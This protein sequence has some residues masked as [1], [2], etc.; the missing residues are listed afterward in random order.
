MLVR[1]F[2]H[3]VPVCLGALGATEAVIFFGA[4]YFGIATRPFGIELTPE[5]S[6]PV[7]PIFPTAV[8]VSVH[9]ALWLPVLVSGIPRIGVLR[10]DITVPL[11]EFAA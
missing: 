9:W 7:F 2:G 11:Y 1:I 6:A 4:M 10:H 3:Y 5:S 8:V